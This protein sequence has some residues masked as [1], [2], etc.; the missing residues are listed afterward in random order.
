MIKI[1]KLNAILLS[2]IVLLLCV[3]ASVVSPAHT[4]AAAGCKISKNPLAIP[5]CSE[6]YSCAPG[7]GEKCLE[8][9]P[10]I[11]WLNFFINV[12]AAVI[13]VGAVAMLIFAGVQYTTAADNPGQVEAA[14]KKIGAV[15]LGLVAF[16]FLYAFLNWLIPGG[17]IG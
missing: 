11:V 7:G 9:N 17:V 16:I 12:L 3:T 13:G 14:K 4:Y 1:N 8:N 6:K 5:D 15:V 2:V 10:I